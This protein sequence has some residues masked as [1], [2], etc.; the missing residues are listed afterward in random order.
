MYSS[1]SAIRAVTLRSLNLIAVRV[2]RARA[3]ARRAAFLAI[4][5][6]LRW[7]CNTVLVSG[8]S[9]RKASAP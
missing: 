1:T 7:N 8:Y 6:P 5:S 3:T 4:L 9:G 2:A